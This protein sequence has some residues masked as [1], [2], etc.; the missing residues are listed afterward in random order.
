MMLIQPSAT[1]ILQ[2]STA[3]A[4][5]TVARALQVR[6]QVK[7]P[8]R[9]PCDLHFGYCGTQQT[10]GYK[11]QR[12]KLCRLTRYLQS[13]VTHA[14]NP[15][16]NLIGRAASDTAATHATPMCD[17]LTGFD[18]KVLQALGND[19]SHGPQHHPGAVAIAIQGADLN[20][21]RCT[22]GGVHQVTIDEAVPPALQQHVSASVWA[23]IREEVAAGFAP[24]TRIS[25]V[26]H[27][28]NIANLFSVLVI[29]S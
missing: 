15:W 10:V 27:K 17:L 1:S 21:V 16:G 14:E 28:L 25:Q 12:R 6:A 13:A 24:L 26:L 22:F 19:R 9:H 7:G 2:A 5:N 4:E 11:N 3:E 18:P 8:P 20:T 23:S 29:V